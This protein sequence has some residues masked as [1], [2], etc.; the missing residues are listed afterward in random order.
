MIDSISLPPYLSIYIY[1]I[2][3][4]KLEWK[5][6]YIHNIS[7]RIL[8]LKARRRRQKGLLLCFLG[9]KE[10]N[11][12][13]LIHNYKTIHPPLFIWSNCVSTRV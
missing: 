13:I 5:E 3:A 2:V 9:R 6:W 11:R 10:V 4:Q 1:I 12:I 7:T 8:F